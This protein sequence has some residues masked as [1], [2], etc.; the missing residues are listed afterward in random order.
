[1][2]LQCFVFAKFEKGLCYDQQFPFRARS[3]WI[4]ASIIV[5]LLRLLNRLFANVLNS[6]LEIWNHLVP[7]TSFP[8]LS[9]Q[10]GEIA[11][12]FW[13]F[14]DIAF[15]FC[16]IEPVFSCQLFIGKYFNKSSNAGTEILSK[17]AFETH[18][19][20]RSIDPPLFFT[21]L[22]SCELCF[23]NCFK[24]SH[25]LWKTANKAGQNRLSSFIVFDVRQI[26][27]GLC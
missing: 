7:N 12:L 3:E 16:L 14:R 24:A 23:E 25:L 10:K 20:S 22:S 9:R 5:F 15:V 1:M 26:H 17:L 19:L 2:S 8:F 11:F 6:L 4:I 21:R 13:P 27:V 18:S